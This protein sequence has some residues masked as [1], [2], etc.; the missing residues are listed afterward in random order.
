MALLEANQVLENLAMLQQQKS[1]IIVI[2]V[3]IV[4]VAFFLG[5][6][7]VGLELLGLCWVVAGLEVERVCRHCV[8]CMFASLKKF[9]VA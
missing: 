1:I 7:I 2:V 8:A 3:H 9:P 4:I 6:F 5:K